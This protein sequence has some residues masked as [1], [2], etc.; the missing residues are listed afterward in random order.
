M[1]LLRGTIVNWTYGTHKKT[2]FMFR[3]YCHSQQYL[4]LFTVMVSRNNSTYN[5][6]LP[7]EVPRDNPAGFLGDCF[8]SRTRPK[9]YYLFY[10]A[11]SSSAMAAIDSVVGWWVDA[12]ERSVVKERLLQIVSVT[13]Q[14]GRHFEEGV[15]LQTP[16]Q[17]SRY[18]RRRRLGGGG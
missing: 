9:L 15:A 16:V 1:H 3:S 5:Q 10:W 2:S 18:E 6:G 11:V 8:F 7:R 14:T 4:V 12:K 13:M 17:G